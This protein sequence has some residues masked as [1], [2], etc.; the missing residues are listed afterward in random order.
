M[1]SYLF[2][3]LLKKNYPYE[4]V[5]YTY[6]GKM[7]KARQTDEVERIVTSEVK[8]LSIAQLFRQCSHT[9]HRQVDIATQ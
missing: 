3:F 9:V 7:F 6:N 8:Y 1:A 4:N 5:L 2:L